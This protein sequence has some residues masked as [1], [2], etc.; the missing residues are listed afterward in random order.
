MHLVNL[1][2]FVRRA[3]T[4]R[5]KTSFSASVYV[6][7]NQTILLIHHRRLGMWVPIGGSIE[8]DETPLLAAQRE[9]LEEAGIHATFPTMPVGMDSNV[10][11]ANTPGLFRYEELHDDP[12]KGIRMN[13]VF[14]AKANSNYV[15][16][17]EECF[18][19]RWVGADCDGMRN[20][21]ENVRQTVALLAIR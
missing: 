9:L 18:G 2:G 7:Y 1:A 14:F 17:N 3:L 6:Q 10:L 15:I 21:P 12:H 4:R 5:R 16:T 19:Y 20:V 11:N 8:R 13:F